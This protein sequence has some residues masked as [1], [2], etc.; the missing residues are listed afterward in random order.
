[1]DVSRSKRIKNWRDTYNGMGLFCIRAIVDYVG[2]REAGAPLHT[3]SISDLTIRPHK[4]LV[5]KENLLRQCLEQVASLPCS[6]LRTT[7]AAN[8]RL[9]WI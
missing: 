4:T 8:N 1:M 6:Q 3:T 2:I 9:S 5:H 7:H